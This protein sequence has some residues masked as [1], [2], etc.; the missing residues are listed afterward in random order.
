MML[1]AIAAIAVSVALQGAVLPQ[2]DAT[3]AGTVVIRGRITE[4]DTG[5]PIARAT[6]VA[7]MMNPDDGRRPPGFFARSGE[8]GRYEI[9]QL[10]AGIYTVGAHLENRPTHL[11]HIYGST[12]SYVPEVEQR[13]SGTKLNL[14]DGEERSGIDI[15]LLR[16]F[17]IAGTVVN[18]LG[19]PIA[20][21][22][23]SATAARR[24]TMRPGGVRRM[25]DDRG[26]FRL[27]GLPPGRYRICAHPTVLASESRLVAER[28]V[29]TCHPSAVREDHA[30]FVVISNADL[31]EVQI[32]VQQVRT[33][34][35]A[36]VI[37]DAAGAP[38]AGAN[39]H[40]DGRGA[41]AEIGG[42]T[43]TGPDGRFALHGI[44]P[45]EYALM[46]GRPDGRGVPEVAYQLMS[47]DTDID[48]LTL[49]I[50]HGARLTGQV[51]FAQGTAPAKLE[52]RM[53]IGA[54]FATGG[55]EVKAAR[56]R[57]DL[58]FELEGLFGPQL[59]GVS[60]LPAG[61]IVHSIRYHGADVTDTPT[62]FTTSSDPAALQITLTRR[63]A[64]VSGRAVD[65]NGSPVADAHVF[66][67][68]AEPERWQRGHAGAQTTTK[69]DGSFTLDMVR[70]GDYL[71]AALRDQDAPPLHGREDYAF[72]AKLGE[73]ITLREDAQRTMTLRVISLAEDR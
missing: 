8:D 67:I 45:G 23:I 3:P 18:E 7:R 30:P 24:G 29:K 43:R 41:V 72:L 10:P 42:R 61:W 27:Y 73:R 53:A 28:L 11:P 69:A 59:L 52:P 46:A 31:A 39:V 21:L 12:A 62:E 13:D 15:A 34:T 17:V 4:K 58:T 63:G 51:A 55:I 64:I 44:T 2:R 38:A 36:G 71:I 60:N 66:L 48:G 54:E 35:I 25:T 47:V 1:P 5:L 49:T 19:E 14:R 16:A 57:D 6:V 22:Q 26:A 20:D 37:V 68:P 65:G 56:V 70:A 40:L 50:S 33:A 9:T 32:R